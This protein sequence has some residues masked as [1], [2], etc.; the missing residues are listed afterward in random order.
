[1]SFP[2][3]ILFEGWHDDLPYFAG[4]KDCPWGLLS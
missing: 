4:H 1:V 3:P 2:F